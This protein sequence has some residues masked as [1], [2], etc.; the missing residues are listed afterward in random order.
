MGLVVVN[1]IAN[2]SLKEKEDKLF[3]S[4][5]TI[6]DAIDVKLKHIEFVSKFEQA[7][8][9]NK[10]ANLTTDPNS[11]AM[12]K[13]LKKHQKS[14]PPQILK[15]LDEI[16]IYHSKLH[17]LVK[18]YNEDFIRIDRD[19][20]ED[21]FE[22]FMKKYIWLLRVANIA[23]G[24]DVNIKNNSTKCAI[25]KYLQKHKDYFTKFGFKNR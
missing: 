20:H 19:L 9:Q 4:E 11:C 15:E 18:T 23:I 1:Y 16:K 13:F 10:K 22:A 7:Y 3:L 8:L 24:E 14:F 12:A 2:S 17:N 5:K 25:G 6:A 21:T